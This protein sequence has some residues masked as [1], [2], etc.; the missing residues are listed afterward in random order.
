MSPEIVSL[1]KIIYSVTLPGG[2]G[3]LTS[4]LYALK[5]GHYKNNKY[6][7]KFFIEILGAMLTATFLTKLISSNQYQYVVAYIIG[8]CWSG[9]IQ[10]LRTKITKIIEAVL[11]AGD[12]ME[13]KD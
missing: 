3:G 8:I 12:K 2:A 7:R 9:I 5:R 4:F 1:I 6:P 13:G 11:T 10:V